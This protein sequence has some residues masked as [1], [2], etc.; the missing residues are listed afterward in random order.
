MRSKGGATRLAPGPLDREGCIARDDSDFLIIADRR[1]A[2]G[3][4]LAG[5]IVVF[6]W[7]ADLRVETL[8][9]LANTS[10]VRRVDWHFRHWPSCTVVAFS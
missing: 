3:P 2:E 7:R 4:R 10:V 6:L 5:A 9:R 1:E 8:V